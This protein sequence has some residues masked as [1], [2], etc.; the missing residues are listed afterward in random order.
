MIPDDVRLVLTAL[1]AL[2]VAHGQEYGHRF[3]TPE[4]PVEEGVQWALG[5]HDEGPP[6]FAAY[7]RLKAAVRP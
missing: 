3:G 4:D 5:E 7:L 1:E 2:A 6:A